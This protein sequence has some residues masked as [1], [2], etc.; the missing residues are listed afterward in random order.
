MG[1]PQ[2]VSPE[3]LTACGSSR[4]SDLWAIGCI[5]YQMI[6]GQPPFQSASEYLIFKVSKMF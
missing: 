6:T 5:I 1:T 4:A 3:I 2:Y